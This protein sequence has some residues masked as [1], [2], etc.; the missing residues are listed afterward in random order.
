MNTNPQ[1][2]AFP[3]VN[4]L[5]IVNLQEI[6]HCVADGSYT[7]IH[8][9]DGNSFVFSKNLGILEARFPEAMFIRIH[10]KY[11]VNRFE[12]AEI[13]L[14]GKCFVVLKGGARLEVSLKRRKEVLGAFE[15]V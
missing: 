13:L 9:Q 1:Q 3:D 12:V 11:L 7:N 8:L 14:N 2:I 10:H 4:G 15:K 5:K 6:S